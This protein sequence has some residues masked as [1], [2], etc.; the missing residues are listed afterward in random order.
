VVAKEDYFNRLITDSK[1]D[2]FLIAPT[3]TYLKDDLFPKIRESNL[4]L[5][6][7]PQI[8]D[9]WKKEF[10]YV[11][12][13]D[14]QGSYEAVSHLIKLGHKRVAFMGC[15]GRDNFI[16]KNRLRG[17]RHA[18]SDAG[19]L[20]DDSLIFNSE[21][22]TEPDS[23]ETGM[24]ILKSKERPTAVF[25]ISDQ[26]AIAFMKAA[27]DSGVNIPEDISIVGFDNIEKASYPEIALTTVS[28]P[29]Y[30]IGR[31]VAEEAILKLTDSSRGKQVKVILDTE[32]IVRKTTAL[33]G[34]NTL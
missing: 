9:S 28:Q 15:M 14:V 21:W 25:A 30:Q 3:E 10:D 2:A 4:P 33:C 13:D 11:V 8:E 32:L 18:L 12:C 31:K 20:F 7:F 23:Y 24:Q 34:A 16:F 29:A 17:Y 5:I 19:F 26:M 27:A 1:A 6:L 22:G